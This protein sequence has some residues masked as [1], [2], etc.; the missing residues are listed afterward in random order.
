M[1]LNAWFLLQFWPHVVD[2]N[3]YFINKEPSSAL[4]G[5]IVEEAWTRKKV[6]Y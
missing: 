3:V 4:D 5:G 1:R 6:N 2:T